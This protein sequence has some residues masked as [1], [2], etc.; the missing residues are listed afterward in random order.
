MVSLEV[1]HGLVATKIELS[2]QI[3]AQ[4]VAEPIEESSQ[5]APPLETKSGSVAPLS[6]SS[7]T[8]QYSFLKGKLASKAPAVFELTQHE[9]AIIKPP[10]EDDIVMSEPVMT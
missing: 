7:F 1:M 2:R 4:P 5:E 9:R 8:E 3:Q 10:N 6:I